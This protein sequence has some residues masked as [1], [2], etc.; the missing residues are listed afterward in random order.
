[1]KKIALICLAL[2]FITSLVAQDK[3]ITRTG[4]VSFEASVPA[5][6]EVKADH[7][8][9]TVALNT[10]TGDIQTLILIKGFRF[11][12]AL[13]EEHFNENYIESDKFPKASFKGKIEGYDY[14]KLSVTGQDFTI[15]GTIEMHGKS[16]DITISAKIKKAKEGVELVS[17]F[18]LNPDDFDIKIP[19]IVSKKVSK[20][21]NVKLNFILQ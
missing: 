13:M 12:V 16:K 11:K 21:V 18:V 9:V 19:S 6:E 5:F 14:E 17:N 4:Q 15:K 1:M 3:K 20:K 10:K 8:N 2:L 7:K